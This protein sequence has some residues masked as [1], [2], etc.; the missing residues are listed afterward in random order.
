MLAR[1]SYSG[2]MRVLTPETRAL[3]ERDLRSLVIGLERP[4]T[5]SPAIAGDIATVRV[6]GG[7]QVRLRRDNGI[8]RVDDFD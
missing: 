5:L 3:I 6:P 7:H 1:R 4:D 8:W 2:L